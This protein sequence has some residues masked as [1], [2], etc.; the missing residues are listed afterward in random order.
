M[1]PKISII[2]I[3]FNSE[4]T[5]EETLNSVI[6][7]DYDNLEY[8]IIDGGSK[9]HTIEI[10]DRYKDRLSLVISEPD[11]GISDAF[12]K[13]IRNATGE[14]IG[15]INSDDLLMP[16]ALK[17]IASHYNNNIDVYSGNVLF[18]NEDS[19]EM[20]SCPPDLK[21]DKLKLQYNVDH[22]SRF[23][24]RDA[25]QK[26]GVYDL[27]FRYNM[28]VDL[29]SRFYKCGATFSH[30]DKDLTKFR[31]GGVTASSI[32]KKKD[33]YRFFVENMGG[34]IWDFREIWFKAIIKYHLIRLCIFLF[35][36]NFRFKFYRAKKVIFGK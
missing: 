31:M 33:D 24:R 13:G 30:I 20:F 17:E 10:L 5:L 7:Q 16:G 12:N 9:D 8:I 19:G 28:D 18:W 23:I 3:T 15:I 11:N 35:G 34:S 6:S 21:F 25:Y 36:E 26:Y 2:T 4:K 22:P 29:L 32:Y 27:R 14:I 1:Q